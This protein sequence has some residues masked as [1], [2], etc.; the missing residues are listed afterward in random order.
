VKSWKAWKFFAN[1]RE[2]VKIILKIDHDSFKRQKKEKRLERKR[3]AAC[4][5]YTVHAV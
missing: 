3:G 1:G 2:R 4:R 5:L